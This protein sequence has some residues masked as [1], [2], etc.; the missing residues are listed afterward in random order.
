LL[1]RITA[2]TTKWP[3]STNWERREMHKKVRN[4]ERNN[5]LEDVGVDGRIIL[6]YVLSRMIG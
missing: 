4:A 5:H 3:Y 6:K 1:R 2:R